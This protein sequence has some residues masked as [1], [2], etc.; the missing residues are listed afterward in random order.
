MGLGEAARS[1]WRGACAVGLPVRLIDL[2][3]QDRA[4]EENAFPMEDESQCFPINVFH[5][6]PD[7]IS[8]LMKEPSASCYR[9]GKYN[10]AFWFWETTDLPVHWVDA[11]C[12]FNEIWTGSDFCKEVIAKRVR[13]PVF[14][15]PLSISPTTP[16]AEMPGRQYF[17]LPLAAYLFLTTSDFNSTAERKNPFAA[18][19]AFEKAFG[20]TP[21]NAY[22]VIK[23]LNPGSHSAYKQITQRSRKNPS[24]IVID[25]ALSRN[26]LNGLFNAVDCFLSPHRAEGFG[27][28]I[29]EAMS[30]G[31]PV[32]ATGWSAN[33][34][35]MTAQN[36]FP[37][38]YT[39]KQLDHDALP[40]P[41]GT[42]WAEP[43]ID[44]IAAI[45]RKLVDNPGIGAEVG[46]RAK[47]DILD[48]LSPEKT[49]EALKRRLTDIWKNLP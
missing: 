27:L 33:M 11:A 23:A 35:F 40:Y 49:G 9:A 37:I 24:I 43:D 7:V 38:H 6:N 13:K 25:K 28:P 8:L 34:E 2:P 14:K 39:L 19:D 26:E 15:I 31:K 45:M 41:K 29:A 32:I 1:T 21:Q 22:L 18:L 48:L 17:G 5:F 30:L 42:L 12:L 46:Q 20:C 10:I 36:S 47:A 3:L 16:S 4:R 44:H